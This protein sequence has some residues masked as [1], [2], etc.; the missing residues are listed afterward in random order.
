[1]YLQRQYKNGK[2]VCVKPLHVSKE[3]NVS[4]RMIAYGVQ[5]G[6]L[7]IAGGKLL[8][9]TPDGQEN[10]EFD[11]VF[12]PGRYC[13]HCDASLGSE[14]E[15]RAHLQSYH[16]DLKSPDPE[17]PAGWRHIKHYECRLVGEPP[18]VDPAAKQSAVRQW[19][20]RMLGR[21]ANG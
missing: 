13:C 7:G 11:I 17:N 8:L 6:F 12:A 4:E 15:A 2:A 21:T 10:L 19:I 18:A 9:V 20:N 14:D 1:M 5:Q 16:F 3:W